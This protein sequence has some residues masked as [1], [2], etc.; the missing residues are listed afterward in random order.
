MTTTFRNYWRQ[1][2]CA[3]FFA[4]AVPSVVMGEEGNTTPRP[5]VEEFL[6]NNFDARKAQR[7]AFLEEIDA[8]SRLW[9]EEYERVKTP[10][11]IEARQKRQR[12][13]FLS[14]L[15]PM[16]DRAPLNAQVTGRGEK[17]KFRYE[18]I[19][20]ESVPGFYV[21]GVLF[22]PKEERF[23]GPY[24]ALLVTEGH[25]VEGKEYERYQGIGILAAVNGIAAFVMDPID[26]GERLQYLD[27]NGK[28]VATT[29]P[30]HNL[31][32]AG[33]ILVG[34][35]TATFEIWDG[36]RAIDYLESREDIVNEKIGVCGTSGGGTQSAYL[37][38]LDERIAMGAP[39]CYI[40]G[41]FGNLTHELGVQDGEQNIW[42]QVRAGIDHADYLMMR[43]PTPTL[44]CTCTKDF[45]NSDD[46]WVSYRYALRLYSR[47]GA[48][49]RLSIVESDSGHAYTEEAHIATIRWALRWLAGRDVET[50]E[51]DATLLT[52]EEIRSLKDQ[53]S[54][55]YLPGAKTA[56]ELNVELADQL[57]EARRAKWT[58]IQSSDAARLVSERVG[59]RTGNAAPRARFFIGSMRDGEYLRAFQTDQGI[60]LT[61][62]ENFDCGV[63][64]SSGAS[65]DSLTLVVS[66]VG[67]QSPFVNELFSS[68]KDAPIAAVEL[69][70]YGDTQNVC[71][72]YYR[73]SHFGPDGVDACYAYLLGKNYV[74]LRADDLLAMIRYYRENLGV[75]T[76]R[77]IAE[78]YAGTVAL[79]AATAEPGAITSLKL[80]GELP[81]WREL[82][83]REYGP[84]PL[85][86]AIHGVL[87]DFDIDDLKS[88]LSD[89]GVLIED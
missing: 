32:Q 85:T 57:A 28:P 35:N 40:C 54:V 20:F 17:E 8:A 82:L 43:A 24:P 87:N 18:N 89:Q 12:D 3:L 7:A 65:L 75:K 15:G 26:Q 66:D 58:G 38:A 41:F 59:L 83:D 29:V 49:N 52:K 13:Y 79:V 60:W 16:W 86:N 34:R 70:G 30:A 5:F 61:T 42:G 50:L 21:T 71:V 84:I 33:S 64:S 76:I 27:E 51:R 56:R 88:Y 67:R 10:A 47:L 36:M 46:A 1:I 78:G 25:S 39:S 9:V 4:L 22:L 45:F 68:A 23:P 63:Y 14:A 72:D 6:G 11:D 55:I 19:L 77:L 80:V 69:R 31:V 44:L 62:R 37:L 53:P 81:T 74:G 73:H 2:F 48:Q